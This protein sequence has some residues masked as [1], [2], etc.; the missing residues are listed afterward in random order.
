MWANASDFSKEA[1]L[2][3]FF[4]FSFSVKLVGN[5]LLFFENMVPANSVWAKPNMPVGQ[6]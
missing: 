4:S 5:C 2:F 1:K 6:M 3:P